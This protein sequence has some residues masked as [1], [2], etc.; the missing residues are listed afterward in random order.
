MVAYKAC[1]V[2]GVGWVIGDG[3]IYGGEVWD[4]DGVFFPLCVT[5][6]QM[7]EVSRAGISC[8]ACR[9]GFPL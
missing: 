1:R 4:G 3:L 5:Q 6:L 7:V 2:V 9:C 8:V